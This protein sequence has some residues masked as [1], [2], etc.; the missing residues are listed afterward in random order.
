MGVDVVDLTRIE[1]LVSTSASFP[2][3]WFTE[4]ERV[5]CAGAPE[6]YAWRFAAK[7]AVW[8]ALSLDA[9]DGRVPWAWIEILGTP[10][11]VSVRLAGDVA[12]AAID[13]GVG[14]ILVSCTVG[15][16]AGLAVAV[17]EI[18][19]LDAQVG[20]PSPASDPSATSTDGRLSS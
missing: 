16:R 1:R 12:A 5:Q 4:A 14:R 18:A 9:W 20:L 8:K 10:E 13:A 19:S 7:E 15:S 17:A 11:A 3:R 6:E 2:S